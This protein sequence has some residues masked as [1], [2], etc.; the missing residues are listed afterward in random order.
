MKESR[1]SITVTYDRKQL[2]L[3]DHI[4]ALHGWRC[5]PLRLCYNRQYLLD[6]AYGA[7]LVGTH[8]WILAFHSQDWSLARTGRGSAKAGRSRSRILKIIMGRLEG[9]AQSQTNADAW[10]FSGDLGGSAGI[11]AMAR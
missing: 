10:R 1:P 6:P 7:R 5:V 9:P 3:D 2:I 11:L 8:E 4:H